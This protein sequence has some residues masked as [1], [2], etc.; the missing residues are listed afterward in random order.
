MF[1]N[2][3]EVPNNIRHKTKKKR[4]KGKDKKLVPSR[5]MR[6]QMIIWLHLISWASE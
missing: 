1:I 6:K 4:K 2:N 5:S 3:N